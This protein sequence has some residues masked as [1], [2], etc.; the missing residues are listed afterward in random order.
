M[1]IIYDTRGT[2]KTLA[3]LLA[4]VFLPFIGIIVYFSFG[5]N[6]RKHKMYANK[7]LLDTK[8]KETLQKEIIAHSREI[9][10][11]GN[12]PVQSRAELV[13]LLLKDT[14]SP[15]TNNN[16]VELLLNGEKKFPEVL[17]AIENAKHHIHIEYY[18]FRDDEI[19]NTIENYFLKK[20]KKALKLDLFMMIT[21][22][23]KL[24]KLLAID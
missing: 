1:R 12:E 15:L 23:L 3:Y 7:S 4:A 6:Y 20:L 17:K 9:L 16:K 2:T 24:E 10:A 14:T 5:I 13:N 8:Q 21:E 11:N 22:A 18:I 19:G